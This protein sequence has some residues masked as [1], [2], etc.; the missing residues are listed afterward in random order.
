[1]STI[2]IVTALLPV[3][4]TIGGTLEHTQKQGS[5]LYRVGAFLASALPG[6]LVSL[7]VKVFGKGSAS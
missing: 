5:A 6:D 2:A 1:M 4:A 7:G 3:L